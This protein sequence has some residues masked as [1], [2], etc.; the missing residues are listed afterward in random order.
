MSH[1]GAAEAVRVAVV[2]FPGTNCEHDTVLALTELGADADLVQHTDRSLDGFDA[3][4]IP[5]GFA[6]G[7]YLR[8][9]AIA[10][11]SPVMESVRR[12]AAAGKPVLGICNGFQILTE[13]RLL[14]G[15]LTANEGGRFLC[16]VVECEIASTSSAMTSGASLGQVLR[17]PINH[18][19][20]R[21]TCSPETL[22]DIKLSD[23][24]PLRYRSNPN[25]SLS[26]IAAVANE[27]GTVIGLMPHP[28]RA[29]TALM[30]SADGRV[31]L[32][33]FL[34][35]AGRRRDMDGASAT[36]ITS[37]P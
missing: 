23:R 10:R 24:V 9:G 8:P 36:G 1:P 14:P 2:V 34:S 19:E 6:H 32:D 26:S 22:Q 11:F 31:L 28:E 17:L 37:S 35:S 7:D 12:A 29:S 21:Y 5:G 3:I 20:G 30:E 15:A 25:G 4:V 13:A 18:F 33:S 27:S 16:E